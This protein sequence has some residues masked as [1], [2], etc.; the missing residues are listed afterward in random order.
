MHAQLGGQRRQPFGRRSRN[1]LCRCGASSLALAAPEEQLRQHDQRWR[2][3]RPR[4]RQA[5]RQWRG[6]RPCPRRHRAERRRRES[7]RLMTVDC[8]EAVASTPTATA[9]RQRRYPRGTG[10]VKASSSLPLLGTVWYL[11]SGRRGGSMA[12]EG[13]SQVRL[14]QALRQPQA[15]RRR[16]E[17]LR[18]PRRH[19]RAACQAGE[20]VRV[21]DNDSGE[22]LTRRHLRA[23][24]LRSGDE[25]E[26]RHQRPVA[27]AAA[28]VGA[29]RRR[30]RAR[31][32]RA[33]SSAAAKRWRACAKRPSSACS[34][35]SAAAPRRRAARA[36][37]VRGAARGAAAHA[38]RSAAPHR[39]AG[40]ASRSSAS[41]SHPAAAHARS[42]ASNRACA[43]SSARIGRSTGGQAGAREARETRRRKQ[44]VAAS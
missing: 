20:D 4:A 44:I 34:S 27:A 37:A 12:N 43:S 31:S 23:D 39:R 3:A 19:P 33:A 40:R 29:V 14:H 8:G 21:V 22:D 36:L 24:H 1:R 30:G 38:R 15:V 2:R 25:D 26:R 42:S 32:A 10:A 28:P 17:P 7:G 5:R 6:W 35:S 41:T 18:D 11:R 13:K 16:G 9:R